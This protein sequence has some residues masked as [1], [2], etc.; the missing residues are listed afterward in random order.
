MDTLQGQLKTLRETIDAFPVGATT[1]NEY[2]LENEITRTVD[3][4]TLVSARLLML[5]T[6]DKQRKYTFREAKADMTVQVDHA[7]I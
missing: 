4:I 5:R 6:Q 3:T 7:A 1:C 2:S